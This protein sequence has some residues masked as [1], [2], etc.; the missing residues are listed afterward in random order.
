MDPPVLDDCCCCLGFFTPI[1]A[2]SSLMLSIMRHG[3]GG[4]AVGGGGGKRV[5]SGVPDFAA[6]GLGLEGVDARPVE[7]LVSDCFF[8]TPP[9][10]AAPPPLPRP[11]RQHP[12]GGWLFQRVLL[13]SR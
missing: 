9:D 7:K 11:F 1:E 6:R 3:G 4:G 5:V 8:S 13:W 12:L 10:D 2:D